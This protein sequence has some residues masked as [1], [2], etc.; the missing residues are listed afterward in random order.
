MTTPLEPPAEPV[1]PI[2]EFDGSSGLPPAA[3]FGI[4]L[5]V[6]LLAI[7]I[8]LL[9]FGGDD[10]VASTTTTI[11]MA[12]TSTTSGQVTTTTAATGTTTT[13]A[14]ETT[15][16]IATETTTT[17]AASTTT[18]TVTVPPAEA[19]APRV[20]F[21]A[22]T[23][24]SNLPGPHLAAVARPLFEPLGTDE[25]LGPIIQSLLEGPQPDDPA[26]SGLSTGVPGGVTLLGASVSDG[27]ADIDL[28][29][30]FESG[31]GTFS[32]TSRLGQLVFTATQFPDVDSVLLRIDGQVVDV[33]SSEGIVLDGPQSREDYYDAVLPLVFLDDPAAGGVVASPLR[34]TGIANAFEAN[35]LYELTV[36][37]A[38]VAEGFTTAT[39]GT[40]CWGDYLIE[41]D[42]PIDTEGAG[43]V[44]VFET[45]AEDGRR[46]N[47][48]S[49][50]VS[51]LPTG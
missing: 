48:Q 14:T 23:E 38:V 24:D 36:D 9:L 15:T 4:G 51:V 7:G 11:P 29:G 25:L 32:M 33:F 43:F 40:G 34:I 31:G 6:V 19:V 21:L 8:P 30:E 50:P 42:F 44:T 47:I 35:V 49:Y 46:I 2:E 39:C 5:V 20:Y 28:S 22:D 26:L 10:E 41:A 1:D 37:G 13:I 45:S 17:V 27:V 3:W 12:E 18:T 16:T